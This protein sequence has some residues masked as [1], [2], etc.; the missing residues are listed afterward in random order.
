MLVWISAYIKSTKG[1]RSLDI[2][3]MEKNGATN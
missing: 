2:A 1:M 3:L